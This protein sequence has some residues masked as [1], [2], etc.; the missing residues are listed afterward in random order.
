MKTLTKERIIEILR[1]YI[2]ADGD[3][4]VIWDENDI[5]SIASELAGQ[6]SDDK[7]YSIPYTPTNADIFKKIAEHGIID[8]S[9]EIIINDGMDDDQPAKEINTPLSDEETAIGKSFIS[10]L[11]DIYKEVKDDALDYKRRMVVGNSQGEHKEF[12]QGKKEAYAR[13]QTV[14]ERLFKWHSIDF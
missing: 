11:M 14:L 10:N 6:E 5:Y 13:I 2:H 4:Y 7:K 1:K 8:K 9:D 12:Y 3:I